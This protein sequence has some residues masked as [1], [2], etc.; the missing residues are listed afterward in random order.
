MK[1]NDKYVSKLILR[2]SGSYLKLSL[3]I[4]VIMIALLCFSLLFYFNYSNDVKKNYT[5]NDIVHILSLEGKYA[6][7]SYRNLNSIDKE[8]IEK[9]MDTKDIQGTVGFL[10]S[11][12]GA[13][14]NDEYAVNLIGA[15][16]DAEDYI[17]LEKM[18]SDTFYTNDFK[19][20]ELEIDI[21]L[22]EVDNEG[23][24]SSNDSNRITYPRKDVIAKKSIDYF[25]DDFE[26]LY[27]VYVNEDTFSNILKKYYD[28]YNEMDSIY[29]AEVADKIT[30]Y[31][32]YV[33]VDDLYQVDLAAE[34]LAKAGYD[35]NYT[36]SAFDAMGS[37]LQKNGVLFFLMIAVL[38][39][40]ASINLVLSLIAYVDMSRKD[41]GIMKF[42]GFSEKRLRAVYRRNINKIFAGLWLVAGICIVL[43]T[44]LMMDSQ[45]ISIIILMIIGVSILLGILD[46][47]VN[48]C[49]VRKVVKKELLF[50][51]KETK[52]FE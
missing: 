49:Y 21:P 31:S 14:I 36:F 1:Y 9:I 35:I 26:E 39:I 7:N 20:E 41:M 50:L 17:S 33:Y 18:E 32:A 24:V 48:E 30:V 38:L 45:R 10:Y 44:V 28:E 25:S 5:E 46:F 16:R 4:F 29:D 42:M 8:E 22:I 11:I 12:N 34:K 19:E 52:Q 15:D 6:D 2:K 27:E 37:S 43:L 40:V 51:I 47:I 13:T 3:I 23:N